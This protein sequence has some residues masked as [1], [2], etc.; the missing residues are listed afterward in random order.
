MEK[1]SEMNK[2]LLLLG[3]KATGSFKEAYHYIEE[4]LYTI[5]ATEIYAFCLWIDKEIGGA[6]SGNIEGLYL[7]FKYPNNKIYELYK[8]D[9]KERIKKFRELTH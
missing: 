4:S 5:E 1:L 3:A 7:A 8:D 6:G 9:I 2:A